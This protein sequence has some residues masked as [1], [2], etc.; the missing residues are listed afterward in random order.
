MVSAGGVQVRLYLT[1]RLYILVLLADSFTLNCVS[2][3]MF[4]TRARDNIQVNI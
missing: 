3:S 2:V 4:V 1:I